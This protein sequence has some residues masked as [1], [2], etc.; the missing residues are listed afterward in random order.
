MKQTCYD[1][2]E[3]HCYVGLT[4]MEFNGAFDVAFELLWT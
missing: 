3:G 1:I 2:I 4:S